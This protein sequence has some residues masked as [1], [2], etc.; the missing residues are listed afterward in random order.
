MGRR[1]KTGSNSALAEPH[2]AGAQVFFCRRIDETHGVEAR[3]TR[4]FARF[5]YLS[6]R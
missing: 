2:A 5:Y 1:I 4:I 6:S 3:R